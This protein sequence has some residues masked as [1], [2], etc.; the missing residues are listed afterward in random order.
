MTHDITFNNITFI[1]GLK[2][3]IMPKYVFY[4]LFYATTISTWL[5]KQL[6]MYLKTSN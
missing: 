4:D 5:K 1:D 6:K 2:A 3:F